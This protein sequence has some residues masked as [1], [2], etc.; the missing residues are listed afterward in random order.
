MPTY[1]KLIRDKIPQIIESK[2][3]GFSTRI[4]NDEDY[5]KYLKVKAYEEL[6]EFCAAETDG[7]AVEE[8]ADLLE[9]IRSLAKQHESSIEEV[10]AIRVEKAGKRGGFEKKIFLNGVE[11]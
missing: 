8:L 2:G 3:K 1:N 7:E 10:E 5:I 4:L 6:D 11:D 9:V